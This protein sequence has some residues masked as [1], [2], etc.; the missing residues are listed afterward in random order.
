MKIAII[1]TSRSG[2]VA[3]CASLLG[4][5][6]K[7]YDVT[8]SDIK[9]TQLSLDWF[10][11]I[12]IGFP[13][14]MGKAEKVA[15]RYMKKNESVLLSK[16]VGYFMCCGF[17]D[18]FEEYVEK[19]IP[20]RLKENAIDVACLGGQLD[21][22]K[23]KGIDRL[24]VKAVRDEI[25]GGGDNADQRDDMVLPTILDENIVQFATHLKDSI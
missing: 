19:V 1:Y 6:L 16:K 9:N 13:I 12:V 3:E 22:S 11:M 14:R 15:A 2:T 5:E 20:R 24:I 25:L 17:I 10:D 21:P 18:C 23:V 7:N 4:R 8:V